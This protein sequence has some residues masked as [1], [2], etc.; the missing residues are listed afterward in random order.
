LVAEP[1]V[2]LGRVGSQLGHFCL[3]RLAHR[4]GRISP[5]KLVL[6][7]YFTKTRKFPKIAT[8]A[9]ASDLIS[10]I[11]AASDVAISWNYGRQDQIRI[12]GNRTAVPQ[13]GMPYQDIALLGME[14]HNLG[15]ASP[16]FFFDR[17]VDQILSSNTPFKVSAVP[18]FR[19]HKRLDLV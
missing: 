18:K 12:L 11:S 17:F 2:G 6:G 13:L 10:N 3:H 8:V 14:L 1:V 16:D 9:V 5:T 4:I 19:F 7:Q 15:A